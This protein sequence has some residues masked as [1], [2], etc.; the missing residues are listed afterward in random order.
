MYYNFTRYVRIENMRTN[1]GNIYLE[2]MYI[3]I[4]SNRKVKTIWFIK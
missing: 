1:L 2:Y 3:I 4:I